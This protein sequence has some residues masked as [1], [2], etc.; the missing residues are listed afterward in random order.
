MTLKT[1]LLT[2]TAAA[3]LLA[4]A[5]SATAAG[6][7]AETP[8]NNTVSLSYD[9]DSGTISLPTAASS[10]FLVD[11]KIDFTLVAQD[12]T[13]VTVNP[14]ESEAALTFLL[15]NEGNDTRDFDINIVQSDNG[16]PISLTYDATNSGAAGTWSL[17]TS[18]NASG[19]PD[20][21]YN[22]TGFA[23]WAILHPTH[24]ST[25]GSWRTSPVVPH[26]ARKMSSP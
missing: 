7:A 15:T 20:T 11:E 25:S 19:G 10:T 17:Y 2:S 4:G 3:I 16:D 24:R 23:G 18:P 5:M 9:S 1:I 6:I 13:S 26:K 22:P 8:V 12:G 21:G 14:T